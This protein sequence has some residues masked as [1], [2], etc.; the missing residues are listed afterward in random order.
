V[1]GGWV[2]SGSGRVFAPIFRLTDTRIVGMTKDEAGE[3]F[4]HLRIDR[5][6]G[7]L[8]V[9]SMPEDVV[10][11][12]IMAYNVDPRLP[13]PYYAQGTPTGRYFA[14]AS[15]PV[16]FD[17]PNDPGCTRVFPQDCAPDMFFLG[18]WFGEFDIKLAKKFYLPGKAIFQ[19]DIDVF[20]VFRATNHSQSFNPGGGSTIFSNN[21]QQSAARTGQ[22]SWRVSW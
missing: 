11:N 5:I 6:T 9:W 2:F 20:N 4:K 7:S 19:M 15:R 22:L 16:G 8:R 14:P 13:F 17:G 3:L 18:K 10:A 21:G 12:T 1:A